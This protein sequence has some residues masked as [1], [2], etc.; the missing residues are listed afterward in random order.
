[1]TAVIDFSLCQVKFVLYYDE[2][3]KCIPF[4]I[5]VNSSSSYVFVQGAVLVKASYKS[6]AEA[7]TQWFYLNEVLL[8]WIQNIKDMQ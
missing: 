4:F 1:M 6:S 8:D 5:V 3:F 2:I 7:Q